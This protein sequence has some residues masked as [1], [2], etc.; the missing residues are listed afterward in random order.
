MGG[1]QGLGFDD[2]VGRLA[3]HLDKRQPPPATA[4]SAGTLWQ[5]WQSAPAQCS[6][7]GLTSCVQQTVAITHDQSYTREGGI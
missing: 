4:S 1:N 6:T 3:A 5:A 7:H 2:T